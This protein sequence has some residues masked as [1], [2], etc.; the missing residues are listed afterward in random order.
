MYVDASL[1][2]YK[3]V[4]V[5]FWL[6]FALIGLITLF[7]KLQHNKTVWFLARQNF[8]A[9]FI[10]LIGSASIDWD[11]LISDFNLGRAH[12][13]E[14]ISSLDKNY[15]LSISETNIAGLYGI[16]NKEGF[17]VDSIYSYNNTYGTN[18][19]WLDIKLY[20]FLVDDAYGDWRSY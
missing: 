8:M 12:Q 13:M 11:K 20:D 4:G 6:F 7:I 3:R 16:K 18:S 17:E 5:Y 14:E 9:L 10:V 19:N 1:L 15:L 2:T